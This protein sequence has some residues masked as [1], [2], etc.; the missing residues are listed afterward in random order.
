MPISH[1]RLGF[2]SQQLIQSMQ[3]DGLT[4][5]AIAIDLGCSYEFVRRMIRAECLPSSVY[6]TRMCLLFRWNVDEIRKLIAI[7]KARKKFGRHFWI[8]L[9]KNPKYEPLYILWPHLT[10]EEQDYFAGWLQ[11]LV[12]R[13]RK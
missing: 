2:F 4:P 13:K 7:D 5:K 3:R 8:A 9:G 12:A 10:P 6:L 1:E 11:Y